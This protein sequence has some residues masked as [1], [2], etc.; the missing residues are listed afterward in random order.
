MFD[1]DD[2]KT[3]AETLKSETNEA[4]QRT[5]VSRLYY[6]VYWRARKNL[7]A[8]GF[9]FSEFDGAHS[10]VWR[11]YKKRGKTNFAVGKLGDR[12]RENR[13]KADYREEVKDFDEIITESFELAEKAL[14]WLDKLQPKEN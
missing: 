7:E 9:F 12:L 3:F 2:F 13:V 6:A 10:Q 14:D 11:E 1:W 5:A 4:A 8:G